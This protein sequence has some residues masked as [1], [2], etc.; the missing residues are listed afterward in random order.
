MDRT[1]YFWA[2][3]ECDSESTAAWL[4]DEMDGIEA[5]GHS[6]NGASHHIA[7]RFNGMW[8]CRFAASRARLGML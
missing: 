8:L 1:K 6:L 7:Y 2:L 5:D 4:Y 3:V